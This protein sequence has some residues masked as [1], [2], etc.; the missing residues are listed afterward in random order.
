MWE[1]KYIHGHVSIHPVSLCLLVGAFN[2]FTFKG[3]INVYDPIS[4]FLI[5][6]GYFL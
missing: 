4:I 5:V 6:W 2:S 1:M 3:I